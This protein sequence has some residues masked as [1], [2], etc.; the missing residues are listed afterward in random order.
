MCVLAQQR[1]H[2]LPSLLQTP[3]KLPWALVRQTLNKIIFVK[4]FFFFFFYYKDRVCW[5]PT[6]KGV[7]LKRTQIQRS[8]RKSP[9]LHLWLVHQWDGGGSS[10]TAT[11]TPSRFGIQD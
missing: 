6:N 10:P 11:E 1:A 5:K 2:L 3:V 7:G 9:P 8:P 4:L